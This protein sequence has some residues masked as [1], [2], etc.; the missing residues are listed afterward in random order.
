MG[1][2]WVWE[3]GHSR[4]RERQ[5][6]AAHDRLIRRDLQVKTLVRLVRQNTQALVEFERTQRTLGTILEAIRHEIKPP[7]DRH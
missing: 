1:L 4:R 2:L 5:L 6:T 7:A 3:R